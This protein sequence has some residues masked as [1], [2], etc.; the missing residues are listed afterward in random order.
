MLCCVVTYEQ[1][2]TPE[3][4]GY[5]ISCHG[6]HGVDKYTFIM[7]SFLGCMVP[8]LLMNNIFHHSDCIFL[9]TPEFQNKVMVEPSCYP[10][11]SA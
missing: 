1:G 6:Y 2:F 7:T 11:S 8:V 5:S 3:L 10:S 4:C 9:H